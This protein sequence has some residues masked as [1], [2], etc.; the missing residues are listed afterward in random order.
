M[1]AHIISIGNE[2]LIGDT[3]NTNASW[4]GQYLTELGFQVSR[5]YTISDDLKEIK[6]TI[7]QAMHDGDVVICTGGLGPTH[8]DITKVAALELFNAELVLNE[9]VLDHVKGMFRKRNIPFSSSNYG[10][11]EVPDNAEVLFNKAGT[12]PGMWFNNDDAYLAM[13]PGVPYEMKHLMRTG[14]TSKLKGAFGDLGVLISKYIKT[15]G[16][17]E[18]TLSDHHIGDLSD[19]L[20]DDLKLAFLP[21]PG[22]VTLRLNARGAD[23]QSAEEKM[24][25]LSDRIYE[26]AGSFIFGEGK[27]YKLEEAIGKELLAREW[28]ISTAESCTGGL[29]SNLLTDIPGSSGYVKGSIVA[30]SNEVKEDVLGVSSDDLDTVGAVSK[31][32]ALQMAKGV[33]EHLGTDIGISTTGVAGPGGGTA[34]KPVG[35][36]WMGFWSK[37][38][39]FAIKAMFTKDRLINKQR[40]AMV[41]LESLRRTLKGIDALPYDL[42]KQFK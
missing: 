6:K 37:E 22:S 9:E 29:I 26:R 7:T 40:T 5:V 12:A 2:L 15:A 41:S 11:A 4:I 18:S 16:I 8:D 27:E 31:E 36:V 32:V 35:L 21:S 34:E 30:Y 33:A 13:L 28:S 17:G 23:Q 38:W 25:L 24:Q 42:E 10:Q 1:T 20:N 3:I 14:V 39:H 19:F